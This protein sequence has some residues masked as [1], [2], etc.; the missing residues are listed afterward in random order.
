MSSI[1]NEEADALT[2]SLEEK[3]TKERTRTF[4]GRMEHKLNRKERF[5]RG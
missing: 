1:T 3:W 5:G 4:V 2:E